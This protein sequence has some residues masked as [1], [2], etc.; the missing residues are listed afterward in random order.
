[1]STFTPV[2]W[3]KASINFTK[4]SSSACTKYFQR[5]IDSL[6]FFSGFHGAACAQAFAQSRS[7]GPVRAL[8]APIAVPP[9]T[10]VRRVK[11][12]IV[13]P[14]FVLLCS[15]TFPRSF[16]EK[17]HDALVGLQPDLVARIEFVTLAEHGDDLIAAELGKHLRF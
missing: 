15:Q 10:S 11:S 4:A 13:V 17:M 12:I 3:V 7:A 2:A 16:I 1:M 9:L 14:P 6:A 8:A 5:S